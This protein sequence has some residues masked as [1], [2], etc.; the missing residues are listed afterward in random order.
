MRFHFRFDPQRGHLVG[1]RGG[2]W[3]SAQNGNSAGMRNDAPPE[4]YQGEPVYR[5]ANG[6]T[7]PKGTY[8]PDPSFTEQARKQKLQ[9]VVVLQIVVTREGKVDDVKVVRGLD[10]G[11]DQSAVDTVRQWRFNPGTKDGQPVNVQITVET[12]FHLY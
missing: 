10:P 2:E 3:H 1:M 6:V 12:N 4:P 8:L 11:L 7:A 9:G 5:I